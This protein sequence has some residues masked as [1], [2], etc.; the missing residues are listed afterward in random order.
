MSRH[1]LQI[2]WRN[3][4]RNPQRTLITI[5]AMSLAYST[6]LFFACLLEG[7][8]QQMIEYGTS[9]TL[10]QAQVHAPG[11]YPDRS[12]HETLGGREGTTIDGLLA[13]VT[14]DRQVHAAS[15]RVYGYGLLS[16]AGRSAGTQLLG[17]VPAQEQQIT[18]LHTRL[19]AGSYLNQQSPKGV[20]LGS[21]LA[22]AVDAEIGSEIV[23]VVQAADGSIGNDLYTV[24]GIFHT[25]LVTLDRGL[26][27]LFLSSLQELLSLAPERIHE[28]GM[29]L[30]D[31]T[32]ATAA[33]AALESR[34][35]QLLPVRVRAWPELAPE[36]AE[37]V[38]VSR[39]GSLIIFFI[40]F[41]LTVVG[42]TNTMLMA[43]F[44]R[45]R[46]LGMLMA[47]GVRPSQVI[48]L[49]LAEIGGIV[50]VSLVVGGGIGV[51][52]LWALQVHGLDLRGF[53]GNVPFAGSLVSPVWY[54][55]QDF[56]AYSQA[57][58]GLAC[59]AFVA[60]LYPAL[61]AARLQPM[62]AL[63]KV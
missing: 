32:A 55:R 28:V 52:L 47:V 12:L 39:S 54:G 44:E 31:T 8:R 33:A 50:V 42:S 23:L 20:V 24:M 18:T 16:R 41:L 11:Y 17:V 6:L 46:E 30:S 19:I 48:G 51:P 56:F 40:V 58:L 1:I 34:L 27:L 21:E 15:P 60:A 29:T 4:W 49:V 38:Q 57:A 25:G 22:R 9:F 7:M 35:D 59:A 63:R 14:S 43:V 26:V 5:A 62:E 36:L 45:T 37:F 10:S 2:A 3:L 13:A 53:M 61:R